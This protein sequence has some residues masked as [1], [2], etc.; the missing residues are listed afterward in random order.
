MLLWSRIIK[1]YLGSLSFRFLKIYMQSCSV[2]GARILTVLCIVNKLALVQLCLNRHSWQK[3][4]CIF[5][6]CVAFRPLFLIPSHRAGDFPAPLYRCSDGTLSLVSKFE[7]S[8]L[9]PFSVAVQPCLY[10]LVG[11]PEDRFSHSMCF[12]KRVISVVSK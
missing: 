5:F 4:T 11:N 3:Q 8:N 10:D 9:L 6:Q 7:I 12:C 1:S 2:K